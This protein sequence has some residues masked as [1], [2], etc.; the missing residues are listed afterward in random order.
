MSRESSMLTGHGGSRSGKRKAMTNGGDASRLPM[1]NDAPKPTRAFLEDPDSLRKRYQKQNS[2]II[3]VNALYATQLRRLEKERN[4]LLAEM[5]DLTSQISRLT[6][7][8][9]QREMERTYEA[10][11]MHMENFEAIQGLSQTTLEII[12]TFTS[13]VKT[14]LALVE[15]KLIPGLQTL[16]R[17]S[18]LSCEWDA[19]LQPI[20]TTASKVHPSPLSIYSSP[21]NEKLMSDQINEADG[22]PSF[23]GFWSSK[24]VRSKQFHTSLET[25]A[26]ADEQPDQDVDALLQKEVALADA[27]IRDALGT[28]VFDQDDDVEADAGYSARDSSTH[29]NTPVIQQPRLPSVT[30]KNNITT[31]MTNDDMD[32]CSPA[33]TDVSTT[34]ATHPVETLHQSDTPSPVGKTPLEAY[35]ETLMSK[36]PPPFNTPPYNDPLAILKYISRSGESLTETLPTIVKSPRQV[37]AAA[38]AA[39]EA[40]P[41]PSP[42]YRDSVL[43]N[44]HPHLPLVS[45]LDRPDAT[46]PQVASSAFSILHSPWPAL[47]EPGETLS[48]AHGTHLAS[49]SSENPRPLS[50][51]PGGT[52][53][54]KSPTIT[55]QPD[56]STADVLLLAS[57]FPA[58][59]KNALQSNTDFEILCDND[60]QTVR[61]AVRPGADFEVPTVFTSPPKRTRRA[62]TPA[63]RAVKQTN[64]GNEV[65]IGDGGTSSDSQQQLQQPM[66]KKRSTHPPSPQEGESTVNLSELMVV[67]DKTGAKKSSYDIIVPVVFSP[68]TSKVSNYDGFNTPGS[69][70]DSEPSVTP[71]L[72]KA[73]AKNRKK[74]ERAHTPMP[75]ALSSTTSTDNSPDENFPSRRNSRRKSINYALPSLRTKLRQGDL[76][77]FDIYTNPAGAGGASSAAT[78]PKSSTKASRPKTS[79]PRTPLRNITQEVVNT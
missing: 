22:I 52:T 7:Q 32:L 75:R 5:L 18:P 41:P 66:E 61:P 14:K 21:L 16:M 65:I 43:K 56:P 69:V 77:S 46:V 57:A 8:A 72:A 23:K 34:P 68:P 60:Q 44:F 39:A 62:R 53:Q 31:P 55:S 79:D 26:E 4:E 9:E 49:R 3:R 78:N 19:T 70:A 10:S 27:M 64:N 6:L 11:K 17:P 12:N 35:Q 73:A 25:I 74:K 28:L 29:V 40:A 36:L 63:P 50:S 42:S 37:K 54:P 59:A 24:A 15:S 67:E 2:D 20:G 38:E 1:P 47:A 76:G 51:A 33:P 71:G 13:V 58:V 30:S 48:F 45:G